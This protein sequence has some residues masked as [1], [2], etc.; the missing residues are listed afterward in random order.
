MIRHI[1]I[2]A[3]LIPSLG[4]ALMMLCAPPAVLADD[5]VLAQGERVFRNQ[6]RGCHSLT[7]DRHIAGPSLHGVVGRRAGEVA[8]FGY[9]AA[10]QEAQLVWTPETLDHFLTDPDAYLPG[11]RMVFWGLPE[12]ARQALIIYLR[13][14][15]AP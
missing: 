3:R 4:A 2:A 1:P 12:D 10:L 9:S 15:G 6:C 13:H 11:T 7:P 8:D 5:A 14:V